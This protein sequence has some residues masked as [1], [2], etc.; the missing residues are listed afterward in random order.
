MSIEV[1]TWNFTLPENFEPVDQFLMSLKAQLDA[2]TLKPKASK[3]HAILDAREIHRVTMQNRLKL[4]AFEK[5]YRKLIE[6]YVAMTTLIVTTKEQQIRL[7]KVYE[8][9]QSS[10]PCRVLLDSEIS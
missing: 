6:K 1:I 8:T 7:Q 2:I 3:L 10:A 5:R 9:A 4:N